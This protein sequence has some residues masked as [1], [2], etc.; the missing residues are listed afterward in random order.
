[1]MIKAIKYSF[2]SLALLKTV[3]VFASAGVKSSSFDFNKG[4]IVAAPSPLHDSGDMFWRIAFDHDSAAEVMDRDEFA[5]PVE[6]SES[7][8]DSRF[9]LW[10]PAFEVIFPVWF[11]N[12]YIVMPPFEDSEFISTELVTSTNQFET[13]FAEDKL[14]IANGN[15]N[16][17]VSLVSNATGASIK[18]NKESKKMAR[19]FFSMSQKSNLT[20]TEKLSIIDAL[21]LLVQNNLSIFITNSLNGEKLVFGNYKPG[22]LLANQ[23][24]ENVELFSSRFEVLDDL[25]ELDD[26]KTVKLIKDVIPVDVVVVEESTPAPSTTVTVSDV[27]TVAAV[28]DANV[29]PTPTTSATVAPLSAPTTTT[30]KLTLPPN[31]NEKS[32]VSDEESDSSDDEKIE[33]K[34]A[35]V[36]TP[37][38]DSATAASAKDEVSKA[39]NYSWESY[40]V[41]GG[42]SIALLACLSFIAYSK[43]QKKQVD[44]TDL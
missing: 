25:V 27:T 39:F 12:G 1:M 18:M 4:D 19:K 34:T 3:T 8:F 26:P 32:S 40:A 36:T 7:C 24:S 20:L 6:S 13:R 17:F 29:A 33:S 23:E 28:T 9:S 43:F 37:I 21:S 44:S 22:T 31:L 5:T 2:F 30:L 15:N 38:P 42:V 10:S 11:K 41:V 14:V 35:E 16:F